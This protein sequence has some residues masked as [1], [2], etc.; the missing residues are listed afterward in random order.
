MKAR[1]PS[2]EGTGKSCGK[3]ELGRGLEQRSGNPTETRAGRAAA[4]AAARRRPAQRRERPGGGGAGGGGREANPGEGGMEWREGRGEEGNR[5]EQRKGA[6]LRDSGGA[7]EA[8]ECCC[9]GREAGR[10]REEGDKEAGK[11]E[12]ERGGEWERGRRRGQGGGTGAAPGLRAALDSSGARHLA[13]RLRARLSSARA[14]P[15]P[16]A[17]A[18]APLP[19]PPKKGPC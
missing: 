5:A 19:P 18:R 9:R 14:P 7:M 12:V 17:G 11:E 1:G 2:R 6:S 10:E 15:L 16:R 8:A 13:S 3:I 4:A